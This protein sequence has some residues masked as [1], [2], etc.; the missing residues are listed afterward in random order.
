M[1]ILLMPSH[2]RAQLPTGKFVRDV[3]AGDDLEHVI[4]ESLPKVKS[5]L[6][7]IFKG[8]AKSRLRQVIVAAAW[9]RFTVNGE[10]IRLET[11]AWSGDR[12]INVRPGDAVHGW[13][14]YWPNGKVETLDVFTQHQ[15]NTLTYRYVAEDGQRTD[16]YEVDAT[17]NVLTQSVTLESNQLSSPIR[18][19]L[20]Y[21]RENGAS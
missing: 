7:K 6:A 11:D 18:Y 13:R 8:K 20:V 5:A 10:Q 15:G 3:P 14:R 9:Q 12:A 21:H 19:R 1:L 16:T 17:G 2:L 4:S